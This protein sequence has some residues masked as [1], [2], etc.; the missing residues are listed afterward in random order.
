MPIACSANDAFSPTSRT[1]WRRKV[2]KVLRY[3]AQCADR[4]SSASDVGP[5]IDRRHRERLRS[6]WLDVTLEQL[7]HIQP[8]ASFEVLIYS[9]MYYCA[10]S[11]IYHGSD[12]WTPN[13]RPMLP[14]HLESSNWP[15]YTAH[16]TKHREA[17][18]SRFFFLQLTHGTHTSRE[19]HQHFI[20]RSE[21]CVIYPTGGGGNI[22]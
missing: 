4:A 1:N 3:P 14:K 8:W 19:F 6:R 20:R 2:A 21:P 15:D 22:K 18:T 17:Y 16:D 11:N 7:R 10:Y 5:P 9:T 12:T 13:K